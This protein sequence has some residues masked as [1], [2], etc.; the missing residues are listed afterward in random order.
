MVKIVTFSKVNITNIKQF[1]NTP[2]IKVNNHNN[3]MMSTSTSTNINMNVKLKIKNGDR[4][5]SGNKKNI[6]F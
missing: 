3:K 5:V 4:V 1:Q 2:N 6:I